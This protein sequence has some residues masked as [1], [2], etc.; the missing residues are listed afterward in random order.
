MLFRSVGAL[1]E[2]LASHGPVVAP[3]QRTDGQHAAPTL[4]EVGLPVK[5]GHLNALV[6]DGA[7]EVSGTRLA[8]AG[9]HHHAATA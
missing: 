4:V 2:T 6:D 8:V 7:P 3:Q 9:S 5:G 1:T